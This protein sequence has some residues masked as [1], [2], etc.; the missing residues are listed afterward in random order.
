ME[1][2]EAKSNLRIYPLTAK[3]DFTLITFSLPLANQF[4]IVPQGKRQET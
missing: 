2:D 4:S 3:I 1:I